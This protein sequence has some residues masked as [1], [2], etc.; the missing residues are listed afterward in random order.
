MRKEAWPYAVLVALLVLM[1]AQLV[2]EAWDDSLTF[3]E[4]RY[5]WSGSCA[6]QTRTIDLEVSN[7]PGH[8][9]LGGLGALLAGGARHH[10]HLDQR[11]RPAVL[12]ARNDRSRRRAR[13][14]A[15]ALAYTA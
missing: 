1:A 15:P 5:V 4:V 10:W 9:L 12:D 7:P 6:W 3:D 13:E 11:L 2:R 14:C 8:K